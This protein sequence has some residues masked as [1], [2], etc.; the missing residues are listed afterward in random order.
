MPVASLNNAATQNGYVDALTVNFSFARK[1][2][3][4]Q[5]Y[6]AGIFYQLATFGPAGTEASWE[7]GEHFLAPTLNSFRSAEDEGFP[8]ESM[9]AGIRVRSAVPSVSASVTVA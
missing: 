9:F 2:F 6:N 8:A 7:S 4:M 5:V 3:S 1:S